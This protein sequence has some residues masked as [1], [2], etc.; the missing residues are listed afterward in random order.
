MIVFWPRIPDYMS[1]KVC[2]EKECLD[3]SSQVRHVLFCMEFKF[4]F[5]TIRCSCRFKQNSSMIVIVLLDIESLA[6]GREDVD[7]QFPYLT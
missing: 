1:A 3:A 6:R 2:V 5:N 7:P 4:Y